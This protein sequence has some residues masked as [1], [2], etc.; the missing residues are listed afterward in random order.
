VSGIVVASFNMHGGLD[1]WGRPYDAVAACRE[2]D[3]DI[4]VLQENFDGLAAKIAGELGYEVRTVAIAEARR[5]PPV[6]GGRGWGPPAWARR[7][8]GLRVSMTSGSRRH[9]ERRAEWEAGERGEWGVAVLSRLAILRSED[10]D[11]GDLP[12][13]PAHRRAL[14]VEVDAGAP[15]VVVGVH[16]SHLSDGSLA[17]FRRLGRVL[18][19]KG[20][21]AVVAG[22]MNLWGPPLRLLLPG[23]RRA[24]HG[25]T[26][27]A[28]RPLAQVDHLLVRPQMEVSEPSV[29]HL[30][31][32][33]HRA[34]RVRIHVG[35]PEAEHLP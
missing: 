2:L 30:G 1:G 27:P 22:D 28:Y 7:P 10:R 21:A 8:I 15:L 24:V 12:L 23:W 33:D 14:I 35:P 9:P 29:Q 18:P 20:V 16:M 13:D 31:A 17:Q 5:Y 34:V 25:R 4:L 26:W 6:E 3:A 19:P 32:S 11:L